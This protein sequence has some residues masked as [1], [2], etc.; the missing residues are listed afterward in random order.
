MPRVGNKTTY[1]ELRDDSRG[2][3]LTWVKLHSGATVVGAGVFCFFFGTGGGGMLDWHGVAGMRFLVH[4][5]SVAC[6]WFFSSCFAWCSSSWVLLLAKPNALSQSPFDSRSAHVAIFS[7]NLLV[8]KSETIFSMFLLVSSAFMEASW[9][10][11]SARCASSASMADKSSI[12][13]SMSF[14]AM[15]S[16]SKACSRVARSS[17]SKACLQVSWLS[18]TGLRVGF[19]SS[20]SSSKL[21]LLPYLGQSSFS[22][23]SQFSPVLRQQRHWNPYF[24]DLTK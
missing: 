6:F 13:S 2:K 11:N 19:S 3:N 10:I 1:N 22:K 9:L 18:F 5:D 20:S 23:L 15:S 24:L 17:S 14:K 4:V 21:G 7:L 12:S 16:S 8:V